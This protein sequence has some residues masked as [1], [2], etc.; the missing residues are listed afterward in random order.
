MITT[1]TVPIIKQH[2][3]Q[4]AARC[5][6]LGTL[7]KS[8][9]L[10][11]VLLD[12][13]RRGRLLKHPDLQRHQHEHRK[14]EPRG[15]TG[16]DRFG[17]RA[18]QEV[19]GDPA[20]G[21]HHAKQTVDPARGLNREQGVCEGPKQLDQDDDVDVFPN[22][23]RIGRAGQPVRT[24]G[25][26]DRQHR[27]ARERRDDQHA[28]NLHPGRKAIVDPD[29]DHRCDRHHD[30]HAGQGLAS[31]F[32]DEQ[33]LGRRACDRVARH[34]REGEDTKAGNPPRLKRGPLLRTVGGI[35]AARAIWVCGI[36]HGA[37]ARMSE[38]I[39]PILGRKVRGA[40]EKPNDQI[41]ECVARRL[42]RRPQLGR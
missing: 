39:D 42:E 25:E 20:E 7:P 2:R 32:R 37:S 3:D 10:L 31:V 36:G 35:V 17:H 16:S 19:R 29:D 21:A 33:R 4:I 14:R 23:Q 8:G 38:P 26:H 18:D 13:R 30:P 41:S 22:V 24:C 1:C 40:P 34:H 6:D 27:R 28:Q 12:R 5:D 11:L 15:R 9:R